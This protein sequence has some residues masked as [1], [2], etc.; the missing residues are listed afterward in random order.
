[1]QGGVRITALALVLAAAAQFQAAK[2]IVF[3]S[4]CAAPLHGEGSETGYV[5]RSGRRLDLY[6]LPCH[7]GHLVC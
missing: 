3:I 2:A 5:D 7:N 4:H 1:M 6:H